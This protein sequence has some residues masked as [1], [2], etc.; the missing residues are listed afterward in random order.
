MAKDGAQRTVA[1]EIFED[2]TDNEEVL[3]LAFSLASL[4]LTSEADQQWLE[5]KVA[6]LEDILR[7][8]WF[9]QKKGV[10][11]RFSGPHSFNNTCKSVAS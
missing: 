8:P 5:G 10:E 6:M 2:I 4:V 7:D 9:Y 3:A 11:V 1:K